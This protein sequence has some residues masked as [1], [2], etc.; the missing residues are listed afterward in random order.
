MKNNGH[1]STPPKTFLPKCPTGIQGLDEITAA[2]P[3]LTL[4]QVTE[5]YDWHARQLRLID[6]AIQHANWSFEVAVDQSVMED[7]KSK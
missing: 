7:F 1:K 6:A 4:S 3:K 5:E 2:F